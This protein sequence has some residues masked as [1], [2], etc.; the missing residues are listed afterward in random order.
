MTK[1]DYFI[2]KGY[3]VHKQQHDKLYPHWVQKIYLSLVSIATGVD[4]LVIFGLDFSEI[5]VLVPETSVS[6]IPVSCL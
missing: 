2:E 4:V 5:S 6:L 3:Q 1:R